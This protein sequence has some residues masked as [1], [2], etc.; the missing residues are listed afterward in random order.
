MTPRGSSFRL[1]GSAEFLPRRTGSRIPSRRVRLFLEICAG[2]ERLRQI[3]GILDE[4]GDG[5]PDVAVPLGGQIVVLA[6]GGAAT[7]RHAVLAEIPWPQVRGH[8]LERATTGAFAW[9][10]GDRQKVRCASTTDDPL[11][12]R[13]RV[14]LP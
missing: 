12:L 2:D 1:R 9:I 6:H 10:E 13:D 3:L 4:G 14:A 5:E 8:D 11:P 7:V